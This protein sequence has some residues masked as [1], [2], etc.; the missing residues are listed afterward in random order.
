MPGDRG[1]ALKAKQLK[2]GVELFATIAPMLV[3]CGQRY[4]LLFPVAIA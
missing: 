1:V 3:E 2:E 4:G